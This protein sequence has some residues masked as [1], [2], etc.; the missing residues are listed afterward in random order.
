VT[1]RA[2]E[3]TALYLRPATEHDIADV[4]RIETISFS[5]PWTRSSFASLLGHQHVMF[6]VADAAT[7]PPISD[8]AGARGEVAGY[9][10][11]WVAADEAEIANIAVAPTLRG[12]GI[13]AR[14]LDATLV[15][16]AL[17]GAST[18]Y[19][20]VRESNAAARSLYAS[21]GFVEVGRR[22]NYYRHPQEDALVLRR[23]RVEGASS[24]P[25]QSPRPAARSI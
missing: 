9:V 20:E 13:G 5:D 21:R 2:S 19:L 16:V 4:H 23:D 10:V 22:R 12:Q 8:G 6:L 14:L 25:G 18:V 15:E 17:R 3:P 24:A 1:A 11:A 7:A